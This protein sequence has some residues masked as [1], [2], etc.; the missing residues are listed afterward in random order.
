VRDLC[1]GVAM[2]PQLG[3]M[4]GAHAVSE[5]GLLELAIDRLPSGAPAAGS[6]FAV[7]SVAYAPSG[8]TQW[9]CA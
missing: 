9:C 5:Q 4:H 7:F 2:R 8:T 6:Q 3:P 1:S